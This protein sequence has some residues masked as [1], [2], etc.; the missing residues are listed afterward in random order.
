MLYEVITRPVLIRS[1]FG[2]TTLANTRALALAKLTAATPDPVGGKIWRD[3]DGE[4]T[5]L[6]EDAA[7]DVFR[8]TSY[9]VCY[10]KLLRVNL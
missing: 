4:P 9:N 3:A 7:Q 10:T 2:H 1:S 5:G 8:I 6:L